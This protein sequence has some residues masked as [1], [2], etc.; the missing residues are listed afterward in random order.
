MKKKKL[1]SKF[2]SYWG[3][4]QTLRV[5]LDTNLMILYSISLLV[6][7]IS[8]KFFS[9]IFPSLIPNATD[10]SQSRPLWIVYYKCNS[11]NMNDYYLT[12][13]VLFKKN[14]FENSH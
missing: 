12:K 13:S 10:L 7:L 6:F 5:I 4:K 11:L 14:S 8:H 1:H 9:Y 3:K 2:Q